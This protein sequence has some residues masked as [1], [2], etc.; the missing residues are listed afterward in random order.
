[1]FQVNNM[2]SSING[3]IYGQGVEVLLTTRFILGGI[4]AV[5]VGVIIIGGIKR[6]ATIA[7][8]LVPLMCFPIEH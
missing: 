3:L 6:I 2:V 4:I 8:G 7:S 1:M 5:I